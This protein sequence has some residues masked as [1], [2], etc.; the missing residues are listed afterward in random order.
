M[1]VDLISFQD[2]AVKDLRVDIAD[3]LDNYRK[4]GKTQVVS[5]QA[6]T[7]AGKTIIAAALIEGIY[8]GMSFP[9]GTAYAEQ[10]DAI[11]VWLSDSPELNLQSKEKIELKTSKLRYGQC[12]TISEESFDMEM[13]E[14]GHIYF[15]NTQ[16]ISRSGKLT[17]LSDTKDYRH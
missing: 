4:R 2:K 8:N 16:K 12:V 1:K 3:A 17:T 15:L 14:D 11:F 6:P 9:D 10:P 7:G 13:L 5:L